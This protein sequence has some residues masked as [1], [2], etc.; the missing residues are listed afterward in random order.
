MNRLTPVAAGL[1]LVLAVPVL[2]GCGTEQA[3]DRTA[4]RT[5]GRA[6]ASASASY[7]ATRKAAKAEHDRR[8]EDVAAVC[9]DR[10]PASPEATAS[11][12]LDPEAQKYAENHAFKRKAPLSG[13]AACRGEAHA[14]RIARGLEGVRDEPALRAALGRLGYGSADLEVYETGGP[15]GF[16]FPVPDTGPC[17]TGLLRTPPEVASHGFYVEGG[18][19]EPKGGH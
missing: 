4:D 3:A 14:Q 15:L 1:L 2:A 8:F 18:C 11:R 10:G 12:S 9:S 17:I 16:T 19:R 7:E 5:A 13:D 6:A